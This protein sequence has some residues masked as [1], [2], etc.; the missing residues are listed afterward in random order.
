MIIFLLTVLKIGS[1]L[2]LTGPLSAYGRDCLMGMKLAAD[3]LAIQGY[4]IKLYVADNYGEPDET[5]KKL[6]EI[7]AKGVDVIIGPLISSCVL[8]IKDEIG[9]EGILLITPSAT[10]DKVTEGN[11]NIWRICFTD[12]MQGTAMS[13]F[14]YE[15]LRKNK[16]AILCDSANPYSRELAKYFAHSF[17]EMGGEIVYVGFY[18]SGTFFYAKILDEVIAHSPDCLF[19][20]GYCEDVGHI[21]REARIRGLDIPLLGTDGWDSPRLVDLSGKHSGENY[22]CTHFFTGVPSSDVSI[23]CQKYMERYIMAPSSFSAL[24]YDAVKLIATLAGRE[25][26]KS[27]ELKEKI[28]E[29]KKFEGVT[30]EMIFE[31]ERDPLK[32]FYIIRLKDGELQ[33]AKIVK[34]KKVTSDKIDIE[35]SEEW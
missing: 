24:G 27:K 2:P 17:E 29:L 8:E 6:R 4:D 20:P 13:K 28:K 14:A 9:R 35:F 16:A 21:I 15:V 30:G 7:V 34:V 32:D 26:I 33:L 25:G 22:Y 11:D 19:I 12:R 31:G 10:N 1:L 3:E 5:V 18:K 23:F